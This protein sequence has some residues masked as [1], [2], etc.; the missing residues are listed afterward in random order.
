LSVSQISPGRKN[1]IQYEIDGSSAAFAWDSERPDEA[2]IGHRERPNEIL[3]KNAALMGP[4]GQAAT[5]LPAGHVEGFADTFAALFRA[6]YADVVTGRPSPAPAYPTFADG[7]DEMLVG[8]AIAESA[9]LG[10]WVDVE[11]SPA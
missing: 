1:S 6:I 10:R 4:S 9:R 5:V 2:W 3:I 7:H 11:R 8:D